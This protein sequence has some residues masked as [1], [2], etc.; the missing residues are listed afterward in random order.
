MI[1]EDSENGILAANAAGIPVILVPD[2]KIPEQDI[3]DK[4][5]AILSSLDELPKWI[6]EGQC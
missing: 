3:L 4:T 2:L 5:A 1:I 6:S